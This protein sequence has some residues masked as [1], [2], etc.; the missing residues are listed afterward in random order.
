MCDGVGFF[1]QNRLLQ[2]FLADEN[3]K[4]LYLSYLEQPTN[5]KKSAI[6]KLFQIHVRK[7]QLLSYFSKVLYFES[8]KYDKKVR[9]INS[10][11]QLI[12][13]KDVNDGEGT[14]LDL[15][16]S[17]NP[18]DELV[19]VTSIDPEDLEFIFE[20]KTL[21]EI[22]SKLSPRQKVILH[23]IYV[24]DWTENEVAQRLGV[25]KQAVNKTKNQS[26]K[27]IKQ[28]Y[29][30]KNRGD[31]NGGIKKQRISARGTGYAEAQN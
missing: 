1:M 21:H 20:D 25:T 16:E 3:T 5:Y 17:E 28:E 6:E 2:C 14:L 11:N 18:I 19:F 10:V 22:V 4:N 31:I 30:I 15:I 24:K 13:D 26:L 27:K 12:L 29:E 9:R 8:Q 7:I 23:L